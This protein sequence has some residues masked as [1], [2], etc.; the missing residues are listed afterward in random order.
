MNLVNYDGLYNK[1][2]FGNKLKPA[3]HFS[4][5]KLHFRIIENGIVLPFKIININGRLVVF[6][7][8]IDKEGNF[9][10]GTSVHNGIG[11]AYTPNEEVQQSPETVIFL[12][13]FNHVWGHCLTDHLK[14]IWFLT[15]EA[16]KKYFSNCKIVFSLM[17]QTIIPS[18]VKLLQILD[19]DVSKLIL[20]NHATKFQN[21]ILPDASILSARGGGRIYP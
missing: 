9:I 3:N 8:V 18:F 14:R 4:E 12:G 7:G 15:S 19:V 6:G 1:E 2:F 16:Y 21:V 11:D 13:T 20:I 10:N 17:G 5:E